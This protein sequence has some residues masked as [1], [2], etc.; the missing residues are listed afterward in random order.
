MLTRTRSSPP[1]RDPCRCLARTS[2]KASSSC[3]GLTSVSRNQPRAFLPCNFSFI[4]LPSLKIAQCATEKLLDVAIR[5]T[6]QTWPRICQASMFQRPWKAPSKSIALRYLALIALS[7][8]LTSYGGFSQV[9]SFSTPSRH[10]R[11][12]GV[13]SCGSLCSSRL[14]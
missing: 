14:E 13:R 11:R 1:A 9:V 3:G 5:A 10:L 8:E 4:S 7:N 12:S 2:S 6:G